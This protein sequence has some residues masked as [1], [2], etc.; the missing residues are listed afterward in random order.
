MGQTLTKE[1]VVLQ[2]GAVR[3]EPLQTSGNIQGG[4]YHRSRHTMQFPKLRPGNM[5]AILRGT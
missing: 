4:R 5:S 2:G 3:I 1:K